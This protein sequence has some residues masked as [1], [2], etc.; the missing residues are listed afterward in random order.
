M[1]ILKLK[2]YALIP[3]FFSVVVFHVGCACTA[4]KNEV[5]LKLAAKNDEVNAVKCELQSK[6][7]TITELL[8]RLS[9]K[10]QEIGRLTDKL[11]TAQA[12]IE[13]LKNDIERLREVDVQ[14]EEKKKEV[15]QRIE[16]TIPL[17]E[18]ETISGTDS[19]TT[20]VKETP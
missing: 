13:D 1:S 12:T 20:S 6:E 11:N 19:A 16:E 18:K 2:N 15:D 5:S 4:Q 9:M 14:M 7:K 10:D 8:D 3:F 17:S